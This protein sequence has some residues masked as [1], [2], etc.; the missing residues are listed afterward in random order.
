MTRKDRKD[1]EVT[2]SQILQLLRQLLPQLQE[3]YGVRQLALYG[4][5]AKGEARV[6]SDVDILV[7]LS[8]PLG[9]NFVALALDLEEVLGLKVDL[10]TF[11]TLTRNE[12]SPR[13]R[14][15]VRD[16]KQTLIYV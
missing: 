6:Q 15:I 13:H 9:L 10:T 3:K 2:T 14:H 1:E 7:H 5:F 8:R 11:E 4:S 16:I 12:S